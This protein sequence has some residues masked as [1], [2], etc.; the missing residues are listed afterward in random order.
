MVSLPLRY[1]VTLEADLSHPDVNS[2]E[3][4]TAAS[5]NLPAPVLN[6]LNN[7]VPVLKMDYLKG[8]PKE[9]FNSV[10]NRSPA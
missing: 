3:K 8:V 10:I 2:I 7:L 4:K 9:N 1:I 6:F 5:K